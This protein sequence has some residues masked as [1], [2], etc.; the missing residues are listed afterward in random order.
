[1]PRL[2]IRVLGLSCRYDAIAALEGVTLDVA[3]GEIVGVVGPNGSGKTTL[4]RALDALLQPSSGSVVLEGRDLHAMSRGE[5]AASVAVVAQV[6]PPGFGF[7]AREIVAM[8]RTPHQVPLAREGAKDA[9]LIRQAMERTDTWHLRGRQVDRLSGGERQRVLLARALA[10]APAV[11]LLDE[12][13]AHLD[14]RYQLEIMD[15][16]HSLANGGLA[17]VAALHDLNLASQHCD[18]LIL[19]DGGRIAAAG[20]PSEVLTPPTLQAVYGIDVEVQPH[21]LTGRPHVVPLGT[22]TRSLAGPR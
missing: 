3:A 11:L 20:L 14:V 16:V 5:I 6:S 2:V 9:A 19:L 4:V 12:P 7:T 10:Q 22:L 1:M 17:I 13:T 15:V 18:R 8:G 21:R